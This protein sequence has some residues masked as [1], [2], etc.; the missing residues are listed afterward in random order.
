MASAIDRL[1]FGSAYKIAL[2][3]PSV[4]WDPGTEFFGKIG[5]ADE[6]WESL[7]YS[8]YSGTPVLL[9]EAALGFARRLEALS[10]PD[11]TTRIMR[12]VRAMFGATIPDPIGVTVSDWNRSPFTRGSYT[13]WPLGSSPRDQRAFA[14]PL[15]G[16]LFFA[17]EHAHERFPG[18]VHGAYLS[19]VAA[20]RR[21]GDAVGAP[22]N[23]RL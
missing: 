14:T 7:N 23:G 9:V 22:W 8:A 20:A 19:G 15:S 18:T 12:A 10:P 3:F 17:G 13:Y 4:F 11:A 5:A 6:H 21:V 16:R 2:R 1:G